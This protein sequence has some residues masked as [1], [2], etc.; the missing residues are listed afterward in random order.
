MSLASDG[1][2]IAALRRAIKVMKSRPVSDPTSWD[3]QVN[4]HATPDAS[5][6]EFWNQCQHGNYFFL[7]WHRM[8]IYWF[9]RILREASGDPGFALPYW[10]YTSPAARAL[11]K[12]YRVPADASNPL[13]VAER[14][15]DAGGV[16]HGARLPA[17]A[18]A[19]YWL[20]FRL[21]R[22]STPLPTGAAFG[23]RVVDRP[24]HLMPTMGSFESYHNVMHVL[25]GGEGGFMSDPSGSS[26]DPV[27]LAHHA[28]VDRLW[29][30]WLD[31]GG[32]RS[33]PVDDPNWMGTRFRFFDEKGR[34]VEMAVRDA[35]D[36]EELGYR[37][38]DDPPPL[39]RPKPGPAAPARP[40]RPLASSEDPPGELGTDGPVQ[41]AIELGAE[42]R[43]A[44]RSDGTLALLVE[45]IR[46]EK[47]PMVYYEV[48]L[49]LPKGEPADFQ[50]VHYA[51]NL[52]FA[53]LPPSS[54]PGPHAA[55]GSGH[56][57]TAHEEDLASL[58]AIDVTDTVREQRARG[59]WHDDRL[60]V[61][62]I[63]RGLIPVHDAPVTRPGIKARFDRVVFSGDR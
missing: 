30:R 57:H 55:H 19:S 46:F 32:G 36:G 26:R 34:P 35:L 44:A 27:F 18:A 60:A 39:A 56:N 51:G 53:G 15:A 49:N 41:V 16:N 24:V 52:V 1:P 23:G 31:Q 22:F 47:E 50:G 17:S 37:Y 25:I 13:Y 5:K 3:F 20:P 12:L 48:Y 43:A 4:I 2:E 61:T 29:N 42:A 11:P 40:L 28:N 6:P 45:G 8:Y 33:N 9:E 10:D 62:F 59:L 54:P 38:D 63:M 58:R 7:P 21:T 14:N